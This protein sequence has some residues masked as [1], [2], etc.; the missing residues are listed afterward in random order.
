M[1]HAQITTLF[2]TYRTIDLMKY[3]IDHFKD[4]YDGLYKYKKFKKLSLEDFPMRSVPRHS[5]RSKR[6]VYNPNDDSDGEVDETFF[7]A[8]HL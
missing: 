5:K 4:F 6:K 8:F 2:E 1:T 3:N 7:K